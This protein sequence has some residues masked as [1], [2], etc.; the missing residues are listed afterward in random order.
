MNYLNQNWTLLIGRILFS[1]IFI[2][3]ATNKIFDFPG[4]IAYMQ[5][6]GIILYPGL[7][8]VIAIIFE[9]GGG[10][11]VLLG[12]HI[13]LGAA[14]LFLFILAVSFAVHHFWSYPPEMTQIQMILFMKNI[15]MMG[16]ALYIYTFGAGAYS[17]DAHMKK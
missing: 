6:A 15:S 5:S 14:L 10:L 7:L 12:W 13:R 3:S 16:G 4:T 8:A 17:V 11:M 1:L 9:L 2:L